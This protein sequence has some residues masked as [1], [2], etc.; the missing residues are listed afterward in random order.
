LGFRS[1]NF[2]GFRNIADGEVFL[3]APAVYLIGE[4][5]QGKTNFLEALYLLSY[6]SS[7]R[8][9]HFGDLV[10]WNLK[11]MR[12]YGQIETQD[13]PRGNLSVSWENGEKT[14][15]LHGKKVKDRKELIDKIPT[16]VF[17]HD[18]FL[19]VSGSP[20]RRRWFVDQTLSMHDSLYIDQLRS[21]RKILKERNYSIKNGEMNL[22]EHFGE[23]LAYTGLAIS[24]KRDNLIQEFGK[25]F[26]SSYQKISGME[27]KVRLEYFP[28]WGKAWKVDE[29]MSILYKDLGRDMEAG[30]TLRGP[31]RDQYKFMVFGRDF[32]KNASTGQQR[33]L[34][35][36]LRVT[37]ARLYSE[38]TG[39][40][41]L[42]LLDDVLLELDPGKRGK[43]KD[44]LPE[45]EQT[46]YTFLPGEK[47][48]RRGEE[49][50]TYE[51]KGGVLNAS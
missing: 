4:N 1:V 10:R 17:I 50:L 20:E 8:T 42:L 7:F 15:Q 45:A 5:G 31:H 48:N 18:D 12:V 28:S 6:G 11:S 46:F 49:S 43:F 14:I 29:V 26:A 32:S 44:I 27:E 23:Q 37:Q 2:K 19:F 25:K 9:R 47:I 40:K 21:F 22:I 33:L 38:V 51:M 34:S 39:R 30:I 35:L 3:D 24:R 16:I 13:E 36:V 41:P